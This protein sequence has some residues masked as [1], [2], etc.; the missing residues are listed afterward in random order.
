MRF[1]HLNKVDHQS[2]VAAELL[3]RQG[4]EERQRQ[5]EVKQTG[6]WDGFWAVNT[7]FFFPGISPLNRTVPVYLLATCWQVFVLQSTF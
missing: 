2:D 5:G 4:E 1:I 7:M 6:L 3:V